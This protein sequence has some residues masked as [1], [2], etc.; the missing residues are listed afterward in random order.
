MAD[1]RITMICRNY[2]QLGSFA[3]EVAHENELRSLCLGCHG[4]MN[5]TPHN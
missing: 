4:M 5:I 3:D 2:N 1:L